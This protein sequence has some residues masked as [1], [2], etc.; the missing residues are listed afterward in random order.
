LHDALVAVFQGCHSVENAL[1]D[2]QQLNDLVLSVQVYARPAMYS[3]FLKHGSVLSRRLSYFTFALF[4]PQKAFKRKDMFF[5]K[6]PGHSFKR[7]E[8]EGKREKQY[9]HAQTMTKS[10]TMQLE[11]ML[12]TPANHIL[13]NLSIGQV[14][15][16]MYRRATSGSL[17]CFGKALLSLVKSYPCDTTRINFGERFPERPFF[18]PTARFIGSRRPQKTKS[19]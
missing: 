9:K 15:H 10:A 2:P 6:H 8:G 11:I 7:S 14:S 16:S 3:V 17:N 13:R 5:P 19:H 1:L 18:A 12:V 4:D